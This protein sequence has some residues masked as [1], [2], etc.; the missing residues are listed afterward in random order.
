[1]RLDQCFRPV[2]IWMRLLGIDL[3]KDPHRISLFYAVYS[4]LILSVSLASNAISLYVTFA[5]PSSYDPL[6]TDS[7]TFGLTL[8]IENFNFICM[9]IGIH[10]I[11]LCQTRIRWRNL[12]ITLQ[13][14]EHSIL[15]H[16][17]ILKRMKVS[18]GI[19][20]LILIPVIDKYFN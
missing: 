17:D 4:L 15:V 1:M 12:W 6:I 13:Q 3:N 18:I 20:S 8:I 19:F 5:E 2:F 14:I 9:A 11:L 16:S 10:L 7:N